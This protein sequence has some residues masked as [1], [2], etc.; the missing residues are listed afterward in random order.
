[1][2]DR[3]DENGKQAKLQR[4]NRTLAVACLVFFACMIGAAY[5]SVPLY[6]IFCQVTGYAGT[7]RRVEQY[8]DTI[9]DKTIHVRFDANTVGGLPWDFKPAQREVTLRIGETTTVYFE[10]HNL[11]DRETY[12]RASFN[13]APGLAGAYFNKV[14]CFCFTDTTLK[15]GED[16]KMPVV[17]FVDP[18][19][20]KDPDMKDATTITLS[21]TMFP[22]EKPART[23]G[24]ETGSKGGA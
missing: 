1:M 12:G 8:S 15:P 10:A 18:D 24:K 21:Y 22:I 16:L 4:S 23:A 11:S 13:V 3:R 9:L 5:A 20:V 17:F 2:T 14:E 6:R 19:I 7:T